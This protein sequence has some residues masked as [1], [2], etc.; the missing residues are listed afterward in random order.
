MLVV[1]LPGREHVASFRRQVTG[2]QLRKSRRRRRRA[3][4]R[5]LL[6]ETLRRLGKM[7]DEV[8]YFSN[9]DGDDT[10]GGSFTVIFNDRLTERPDRLQPREGYHFISF[11]RD[12]ISK[13][14]YHFPPHGYIASPIISSTLCGR[15]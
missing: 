8:T 14:G 4:G 11:P 6:D 9:V 2:R 12:I 7:H 10:S 3:C 1:Y 13:R 5:P 15:P